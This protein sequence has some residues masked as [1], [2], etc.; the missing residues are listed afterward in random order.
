MPRLDPGIHDET[1]RVGA[2]RKPAFAEPFHG[3]PGQVRHRQR[4]EAGRPPCLLF[5]GPA[6]TSASHFPT[7]HPAFSPGF[8]EGFRTQ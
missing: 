6:A 1:R 5:G 3:L 4:V 8:H 7:S 2:Y